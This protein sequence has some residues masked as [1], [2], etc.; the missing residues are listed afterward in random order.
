M[1]IPAHTASAFGMCNDV[2]DPES[3]SANRWPNRSDVLKVIFAKI[4]ETGRWVKKNP[5]EAATD[6]CSSSKTRPPF[7]I[8]PAGLRARERWNAHKPHL[9]LIAILAGTFVGGD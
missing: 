1:R 5:K 2:R 4:D 3:R 7:R 8:L 9:E 6:C